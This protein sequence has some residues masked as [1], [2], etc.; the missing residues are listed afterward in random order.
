MMR[1]AAATMIARLP[2]LG[3]SGFSALHG[4]LGSSAS[5]LESKR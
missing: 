3:I 4:L 2:A 1:A 5:R